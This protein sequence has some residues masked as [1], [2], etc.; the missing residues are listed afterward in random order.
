MSDGH[1]RFAAGGRVPGRVR[2]PADVII[3]KIAADGFTVFPFPFPILNFL[4][5]S[6]NSILTPVASQIGCAV[7]MVRRKGL[8][9]MPLQEIFLYAAAKA[10]AMAAPSGVNSG[11]SPAPQKTLSRLKGVWPWRRR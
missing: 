9:K 1:G 2:R 7:A 11:S 3:V 4:R 5:P 10:S 6:C 8:A